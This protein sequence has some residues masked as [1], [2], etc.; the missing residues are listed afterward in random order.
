MTRA[1]DFKCP[2]GHVTE[3][4]LNEFVDKVECGHTNLYR[5]S[6]EG[7]GVCRLEGEYSPSFWYSSSTNNAQRLPPTVVHR[8]V[9]TGEYRFPGVADAPVPAGCERIELDTN[10]VR[11][12]E[13]TI[14]AKD[15]AKAEKFHDARAKFLDGQL[16]E[17]RRV[18]EAELLPKFSQRG[19]E[20]YDKMRAASEAKQKAGRRKITPE[21]Y[22]E[23]LSMDSSNRTGYRDARNDWGRNHGNNK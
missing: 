7:D 11:R 8:D 6:N 23:A 22:V 18:M 3:H 15:A 4:F 12:L 17:N 21:F 2:E 5:E 20:F 14:N 10:G 9:I 16:A 19:R 1:Y 13:H